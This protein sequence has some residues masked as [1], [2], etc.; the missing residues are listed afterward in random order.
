MLILSFA[1]VFNSVF[2]MPWQVAAT[3]RSLNY[4][5]GCST[6]EKEKGETKIVDVL[7]L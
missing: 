1:I 2:G 4:I 7:E 5:E 6:I 3:V